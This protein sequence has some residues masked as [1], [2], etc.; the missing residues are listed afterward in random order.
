MVRRRSASVGRSVVSWARAPGSSSRADDPVIKVPR[1][2]PYIGNGYRNPGAHACHRRAEPRLRHAPAENI[3][4]ADRRALVRPPLLG[5]P[6][7]R[8]QAVS[9]PTSPGIL[10]RIPYFD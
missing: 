4:P 7:H 1:F 3:G 9:G 5:G 2:L 8:T 6:Y 10:L